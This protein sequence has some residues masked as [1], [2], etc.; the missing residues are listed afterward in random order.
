MKPVKWSI[1]IFLPVLIFC[2]SNTTKEAFLET[3]KVISNVTEY[4]LESNRTF[5]GIPSIEVAEN[6][7]MWATWYAGPTAAEDSNNYVI[8]MTS[9]DGENWQISHIVDPDVEGPV[10]VFDPEL[11]IDPTG[12]LWAFWAQ[13]I[14]HDGTIGGVWAM[15]T[16]NPGE[17]KP[18]WSAPKRLTD[19]VMMCKPVV[20]S[21]GEWVLPASTWRK[22]DNSAR[23]VVSTDKG[24]TWTVRGGCNVPEKERS[25][26]EHMIIEK[27]DGSLWLLAR[28]RYGIGESVSTDKGATWPELTPS[29]IQH[30]A[31]RFFIRRLDSGKLLLVKHGPLDEQ[32]GR[33]HLTAYLSDDDGVK[34]YGG[35]LLDERESISY[36]D[37]K[38]S[39]DG[40]IH[41]IYDFARRNE[42]EI[43]MAS[44]TEA[45]VAAGK[46]VS[47]ESK[48][49]KI[50]NKAG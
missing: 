11:W 22:T 44:F 31:A 4:Y 7:R 13:T 29:D 33:S 12:K 2:S 3:P 18:N 28:T 8:V 45:D 46:L 20:L 37:G 41:I 48:L 23:V 24:E 32:T 17:A 38:Q 39:A 26:D 25:F 16:E 19:G 40:T 30:P 43:L 50:V 34:W 14:G 35:L 36:P 49:K 27:T 47:K 6:G 1:L 5:Q 10:R 15:T 9:G 21:S 42:M